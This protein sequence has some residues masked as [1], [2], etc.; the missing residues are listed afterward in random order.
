ME[1]ARSLGVEDLTYF[2]RN[3]YRRP[4][5]DRRVPEAAPRPA[6]RARPAAGARAAG[7]DLRH[8]FRLFGRRSEGGGSCPGAA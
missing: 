7:V 6:G 1:V 4:R 2:T 8:L 3:A 5:P